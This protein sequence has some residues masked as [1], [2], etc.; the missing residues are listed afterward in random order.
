ML[1]GFLPDYW[2]FCQT[3][4][5]SAKLLGFLPDYWDF[6]QTIEIFS[7]LLGF[8]PDYWD[9]NYLNSLAEIPIIRQKSQ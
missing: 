2:D 3:I 8:L 9:S 6:C 7:K 1:L 4:E 5:I